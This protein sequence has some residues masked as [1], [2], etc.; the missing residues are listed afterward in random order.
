VK[1]ELVENVVQEENLS[2]FA[3]TAM[4]NTSIIPSK[5]RKNPGKM[6]QWFM[7]TRTDAQWFVQND[8]TKSFQNVFAPDETYFICLAKFHKRPY[9]NKNYMYVKWGVNS[10]YHAVFN[11][12]YRFISPNDYKEITEEMKESNC[13]FARK[14]I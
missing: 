13:L 8:D 7:M 4:K 11:K 12:T 6:S 2:C 3:E 1:R 10:R 5:Y 9:L 14:L